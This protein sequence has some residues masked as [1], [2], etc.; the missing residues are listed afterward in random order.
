MSFA[1]RFLSATAAI[2][3]MRG[4]GQRSPFQ[5][6]SCA[7]HL[8]SVTMAE[9][10]TGQSASR[11]L[12]TAASL[13]SSASQ[14]VEWEDKFNLVDKVG[15]VGTARTRQDDEDEDE[16]EDNQDDDS[17]HEGD[18]D[19]Q[20]SESSPSRS[21]DDQ[22]GGSELLQL[23]KENNSLVQRLSLMEAKHAKH[24]DDLELKLKRAIETHEEVE[25]K[26]KMQLETVLHEQQAAVEN[27]R[28]VRSIL[29]QVS[30]WVRQVQRSA[31]AERTSRHLVK[32]VNRDLVLMMTPR[33]D[34]PYTLWTTGANLGT[35]VPECLAPP[36]TSGSYGVQ[37][38]E[39]RQA[40]LPPPAPGRNRS[41]SLPGKGFN[42]VGYSIASPASRPSEIVLKPIGGT[43]IVL[44]GLPSVDCKP[45]NDTPVPKRSPGALFAYC[46]QMVTTS[47]AGVRSSPEP[48]AKVTPTWKT[49]RLPPVR[50]ELEI[51][52]ETGQ[53][54]AQALRRSQRLNVAPPSLS[55]GLL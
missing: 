9:F 34:S 36:T 1:A 52:E 15:K 44:D 24:I 45:H 18:E 14:G 27:A 41:K 33:N 28:K 32:P 31:Q 47:L 8:A 38:D 12:P 16:D 25:K 49:D 23:R 7:V 55:I 39:P 21:S 19:V 26:L 46:A 11:N 22:L 4:S 17:P 51:D 40:S 54:S 37:I 35:N 10:A 3:N 29:T 30:S 42:Y 53:C 50:E 13:F 2:L 6:S 20:D 5:L 43:E 48:R